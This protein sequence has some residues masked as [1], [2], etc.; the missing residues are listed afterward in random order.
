MT[1]KISLLLG[2]LT[3]TS[4]ASVTLN[5]QGGALRDSGGVGISNGSLIGIFADNN[6]ADTANLA[7]TGAELLNQ[8]LTLGNTYGNNELIGLFAADSTILGTAGGFNGALNFNL[9]GGLVSGAKL[10]IFWFTDHMGGALSAGQSYGTYT[11]GTI[12]PGSGSNNALLL[13][14]DGSNVTIAYFDP[15]VL[16]GGPSIAE[17][18]ASQTISAVPEPSSTALLGLGS[19]ALLLRRRR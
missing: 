2:A 17:F 7:P 15:T 19:V 9:D 10:T 18:S 8:T 4:H 6:V 3:L 1:L 14:T 16:A 5:F 11:S 13:P 12:Q